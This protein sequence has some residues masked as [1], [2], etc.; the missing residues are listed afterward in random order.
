VIACVG[1]AFQAVFGVFVDI[2]R[3]RGRGSSSHGGVDLVIHT[4]LDL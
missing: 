3:H 1:Q 4:L 2:D